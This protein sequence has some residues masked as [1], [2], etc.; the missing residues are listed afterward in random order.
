MFGADGGGEAGGD[1]KSDGW[2]R[3]RRDGCD[4]QANADGSSITFI[5]LMYECDKM[6][7]TIYSGGAVMRKRKV[8]L[9]LL[10]STVASQCFAPGDSRIVDDRSVCA[11]VAAVALLRCSKA[12]KCRRQLMRQPICARQ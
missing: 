6:Y 9:L 5:E 7:A 12:I 2:R 4:G 11:R 10:L 8:L 1:V 3:A